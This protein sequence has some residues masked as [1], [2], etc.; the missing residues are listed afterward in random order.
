MGTDTDFGPPVRGGQ[1][2]EGFPGGRVRP[3][4]K[5]RGRRR[6]GRRVLQAV[7]VLAVLMGLIPLALL[8]TASLRMDKVAI[9]GLASGGA[10]VNVLLA[11]SDSREGMSREEQLELS[12]GSQGGDLTDTIIVA[13]MQGNRAALLAFPRDLYVT[14]CDGSQGR[15]NAAVHV[16]GPECL[17]DTVSEL[18][19]L[20]IHHYMEIRF[21]GF[22]DVVDALGG[23]EM[24]LD[25]P[26]RDANAGLDLPAGC[27]VLDGGD[28]LGYVRV[29]GI[30]DD[31]GR[32]DRQQ[33]FLQVVASEATEPRTLINIPKMFRVAAEGG[34]AL[35]ASDS[36]GPFS[37]ARIGW[38]LR[39]LAGGAP[40]HTV[41][42]S[43]ASVGGASVLQPIASEAAP[44]FERFR[45]GAVLDEAAAHD[46]GIA[47][48]D[49]SVTVLNGSGAS[50]LAGSVAEQLE[51]HGYSIAAIGNA[52]PLDQTVVRHPEGQEEQARLVAAEAPGDVTVEE[53]SVS[54]VTLILGSDASPR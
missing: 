38:G 28:S 24:C 36:V 31:F 5:P 12:T 21:L 4:E 53:A 6:T 47:P 40:T 7:L 2:R 27:Q 46:A 49:V 14:R 32:M 15:I 45:S 39:G 51:A 23:V 20:P 19:G 41:P 30:D 16:G 3:P 37:L 8:L 25:E 22:R 35:L 11:G 18:S 50:G 42:G 10:P 33:E 44:L 26:I 9:D 17:V 52:D 13:S 34:D 54:S 48:E 1:P 29:R 43:P